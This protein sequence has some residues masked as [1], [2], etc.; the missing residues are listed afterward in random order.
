MY[1]RQAFDR[2]VAEDAPDEACELKRMP[3]AH[4]DADVG[5]SRQRIYHEVSIPSARVEAGLHQVHGA[6]RGRQVS[7][8]KSFDARGNFRILFEIARLR[9]DR[10]AGG[11]LRDFDG[12]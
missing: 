11:V 5:L 8:E 2:S 1:K 9:V 7:V 3:I 12:F 10:L 4:G 6:E